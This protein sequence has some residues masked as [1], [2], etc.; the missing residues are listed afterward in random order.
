MNLSLYKKRIQ[1]TGDLAP[2]LECLKKIHLN[3]VLFVPFE[4]LDITFKRRINLDIEHIYNKVIVHHRGGYCYELNY[5]FYNLLKAIGFNC[6][7]ISSRIY[8][9]GKLGPEFDHMSIIVYLDEP[10]LADVGYGDLFLTPIQISSLTYQDDGL[11][12]F[13][14]DVINEKQFDLLET[15]KDHINFKKKYL[16]DLNECDISDFENQNNIKQVNPESY[17]VKNTICTLPT[18]S[19][20]K[21]I[22]NDTYKVRSNELV[23]DRKIEN[24]DEMLEILRAEFN[25]VIS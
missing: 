15:W 19:G 11:K 25:I 20:R 6:A 16:F 8:D 12:F 17:F 18:K 9:E 5:L 3:H 7:M 2:T 1:Y 23:T 4:A 13:K 21:T 10:W 14:V 22:F 24:R